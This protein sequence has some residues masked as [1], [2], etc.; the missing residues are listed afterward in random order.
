[1][2]SLSGPV[3]LA[4]FGIAWS[5][6]DPASEPADEKITDVGTSSYRAPELMFGTTSY[7]HT[8]DLWAAGCVAA[9]VVTSTCKP[10]FDSGDLGSDLTLIQSIFK[11]LGTPTTESWP[12]SIMT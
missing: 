6:G 10:L 5:P 7:D 9:E 11:A 4:D 12:V 2:K 3:Y 1:M 8:L